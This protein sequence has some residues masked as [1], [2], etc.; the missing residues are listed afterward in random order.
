[1]GVEP[2]LA[3]FVQQ[4]ETCSLAACLPAITGIAMQPMVRRSLDN[5][6]PTHRICP[7]GCLAAVVADAVR[8][9]VM[10]ASWS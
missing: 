3:P 5:G 9:I 4:A 6:A 7:L 8:K 1:M 10:S 2:M